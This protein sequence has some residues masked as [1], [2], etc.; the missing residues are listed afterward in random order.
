[1]NRR[2]WDT[3]ALP[4]GEESVVAVRQ[5]FDADVSRYDLVN[6]IMTFGSPCGGAASPSARSPCSSGSTV[7]DLASG[8]GDLC[9]DLG[10][11]AGLRPL[12]ADL[13]WH[14]RRRP[15][16]RTTYPGR[17]PAPA[18]PQPDGAVEVTCGFAAQPRRPVS[19]LR[20]ARPCGAPRADRS[21]LDVGIPHTR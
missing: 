7:L 3:E 9:I 5:M 11:A 14:A 12:S 20:R 18:L 19:V 4:Q 1:M 17:H 8:T 16:R 13:S 10:R 15:Q 21:L 2:A 6:R